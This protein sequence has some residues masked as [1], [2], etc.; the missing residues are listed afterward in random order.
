ML[1]KMKRFQEGKEMHILNERSAVEVRAMVKMR[2]WRFWLPQKRASVTTR[3]PRFWGSHCRR[4]QGRYCVHHGAH[5]GELARMA[6]P[7][8]WRAWRLIAA[9]PASCG[10]LSRLFSVSLKSNCR[11][12]HR[13]MRI[14][15]HAF[16]VL[17][18]PVCFCCTRCVTPHQN[19]RRQAVKSLLM[20]CPRAFSEL[21]A[22]SEFS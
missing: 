18:K 6:G 14:P 4:S 9:F 1:Y 22:V 2:S 20:S 21:P 7:A 11:D 3:W 5:R 17:A 15:E 13:S 16:M 19:V 12:Q 8:L 10:D